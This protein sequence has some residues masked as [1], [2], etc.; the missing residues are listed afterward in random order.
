MGELKIKIPNEIEQKFR[1]LAMQR[2]G[3][4]K[5]SISNAAQEAIETWSLDNQEKKV[6]N[7]EKFRGIIK[8]KKT[9]VELQHE[10]WNNI[11]EKNTNRR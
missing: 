5:G 10:A 8:S 3:F 1:R 4:S 7:F 2:F 11:H 9:S 6:V